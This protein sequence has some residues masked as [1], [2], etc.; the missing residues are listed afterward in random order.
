MYRYR[1]QIKWDYKQNV[2]CYKEA[3]EAIRACY[4]CHSIGLHAGSYRSQGTRSGQVT[5]RAGTHPA[6]RVLP[7]I[8]TCRG[9][10]RYSIETNLAL[11]RQFTSN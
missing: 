5:L 3:L 7:E 9:Y 1:L 8:C 10:K 6:V 4:W 11:S 2:T